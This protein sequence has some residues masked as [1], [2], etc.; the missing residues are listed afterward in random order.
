MPRGTTI[1][2]LHKNISTEVTSVNGQERDQHQLQIQNDWWRKCTK[3]SLR[4][5]WLEITSS[6]HLMSIY[7]IQ[8]GP[9]CGQD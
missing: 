9:D 8:E 6:P 4:A 2:M 5:L 7:G 1:P 3:V